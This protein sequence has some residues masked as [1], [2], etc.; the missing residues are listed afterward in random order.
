[1]ALALL[2]LVGAGLLGKSLWR[3]MRVDVGIDPEHVLSFQLSPPAAT[4]PDDAAVQAMYERLFERLGALPDVKQVGSINIAPLTGGFDGNH[5]E[6]EVGPLSNPDSR[7]NAQVRTVTPGYFPTVELALRRGRLLDDRDRAGTVSVAVVSESFARAVW[8]GDDPLGKRF[9][10]GGST[11][12]TVGVVTDVKHMKLEEQATPM[13]Y[14]A[15]AQEVMSWHVRRTTIVLRTAEDP[16]AIVPAVRAQVRA[17]DDR[18]PMSNVLTMRQVIAASATPPRFRTLLIGTFSA[19]AL[20]LATLGIY[21]VVSYS[22]T[23]RSREMA[24]RMALGARARGVLGLV[25]RQGLAPVAV[26]IGVGL[27]AARAL[28]RVLAAVLFEV[29]TMDALVFTGVPALMLLVAA[30]ATI[31][32]ARRATRVAPMEALRQD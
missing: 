1:V 7:F 10:A 13:V 16:S 18:L 6:P 24:I 22:V 9:A 5:I 23:Q 2:L 17:I 3:L 11:V 31:A 25:L 32:P 28:S 29:T 12:E 20:L 15:R 14:L 27:L 26:G 19:L 21:G 4:Y 30:A 8:P